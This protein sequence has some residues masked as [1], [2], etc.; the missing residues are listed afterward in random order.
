MT[1]N[2]AILPSAESVMPVQADDALL[3]KLD[4][5]IDEAIAADKPAPAPPE[6]PGDD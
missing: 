1:W 3:A 2:G 6:I 5:I 4:A